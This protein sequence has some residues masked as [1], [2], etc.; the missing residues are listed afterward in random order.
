MTHQAIHHLVFLRF[1]VGFLGQ[2]GHGTWWDCSF[3]SEAGL[4]SLAYNFSRAPLAAAYSAT[5][6]AAKRFHDERIGRTGVTHLF[7]FDPDLEI[8]V[9]RAA[10]HEG[11]QVLKP[12]L[13]NAGALMSELARIAKTEIDSPEGPVQVGTLAQAGTER[14]IIE[15]ARHYHAAFKFG[16][17]IFPYFAAQRT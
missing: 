10:N 4:D 9:Q 12:F 8:L 6:M 16:H 2:K 17:R 7:R 11:A 14:G 13:F 15:L 5:C 1:A 3:L